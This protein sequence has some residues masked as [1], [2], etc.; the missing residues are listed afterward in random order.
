MKGK[1]KWLTDKSSKLLNLA[2]IPLPIDIGEQAPKGPC[3]GEEWEEEI[4]REKPVMQ[5]WGGGGGQR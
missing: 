2:Q 1:Q 3:G 5:E 4:Q